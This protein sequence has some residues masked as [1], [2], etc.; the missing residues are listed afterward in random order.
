MRSFTHP[1][2]SPADWDGNKSAQ[3]ISSDRQGLR[4]Q[5]ESSSGIFQY[6]T[7]VMDLQGEGKLLLH[8]QHTWRRKLD[9]KKKPKPKS[10]HNNIHP[11]IL[12]PSIHLCPVS[13]RPSRIL[14]TNQTRRCKSSFSFP[15]PNTRAYEHSISDAISISPSAYSLSLEPSVQFPSYLNTEIFPAPLPRLDYPSRRHTQR[16]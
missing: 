11:S 3:S 12:A 4:A 14:P 6:L 7:L 10:R 9:F 13:I 1:S 15:S 16:R 2:I 8:K 5:R